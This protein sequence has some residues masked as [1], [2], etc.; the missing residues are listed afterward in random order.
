[1]PAEKPQN[2]QKSALQNTVTKKNDVLYK[3]E[4]EPWYAGI[5]FQGCVYFRATQQKRAS[6][7]IVCIG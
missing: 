4:M 7:I 5:C 3:A 6:Q 1:M 2:N